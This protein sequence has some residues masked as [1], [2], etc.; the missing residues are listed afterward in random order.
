M[1]TDKYPDTPLEEV[2]LLE[3]V[4]LIYKQIPTTVFG[5]A[6]SSLLIIIAFWDYIPTHITLSWY[7]LTI[8]A[9][10][11]VALLS[12][13]FKNASPS[14]AQAR[15]WLKRGTPAT[16]IASFV[17]GL[18][19]YFL[20]VPD[21]II[22]QLILMIMYLTWSSLASHTVSTY[23]PA[24][25]IAVTTNLTPFTIRLLS[26][27][28]FIHII[29][30]C[31]LL[32]FTVVLVNYYHNTNRLVLDSIKLR[33]E[34][35]ALAKELQIQKDNAEQANL[36]KSRFLA[37]A[38]H[39]LR[40]PL[41]AL[42]LFVGELGARLSDDKCKSIVDKIEITTT[43]MSSLF[44]A[45]LDISKLDAGGIKPNIKTF[46]IND[47]LTELELESYPL[48]EAKGLNFRV[49]PCCV[50][51]RSDPALLISVLRNLVINAIR[52]TSSGGIVLG[53]RRKKNC[54]AV[55]VWDSGIG[56]P[57]DKQQLIF[58]E[59][60]QLDNPER[61][62]NK[63]IGL[64]LAISYRIASLLGHNIR[65][66]SRVGSGSR[67]IVELPM[68]KNK[69]VEITGSTSSALSSEKLDLND[70]NIIIIDDNQTILDSTKSLLNTWGCHVITA[71]SISSALD[72]MKISPHRPD[73]IIT[74]Y[75]LQGED[76]GMNAIEAI[77]SVINN[78]GKLVPALVVTGDIAPEIIELCKSNGYPVF[79]KPVRPEQL[80]KIISLAI[81]TS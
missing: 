66:I 25:Y 44:N 20:Y 10:T 75:R 40:Q 77:R 5:I 47:L 42:S 2:I 22:F 39:D 43:S 73:V 55:E 12:Q 30:I 76:T 1:N 72:Q 79:H 68:A 70:V 53:C 71:T 65:I 11:Y 4:K 54:I 57:E 61:D 80:R 7:A 59:F 26:D 45:L 21:S 48:A 35:V 24:F 34:H 37:A 31:A 69:A 6:A 9:W 23:P 29:M 60:Y 8:L 81:E 27:I 14:P 17:S 78:T 50:M 49:V 63:G 3:Q 64:G 41:H 13:Q 19:G 56:I 46:P 15:Y 62:Q 28:N 32:V 36:V 33:F 16:A 52:Y 67:F 51:V 58:Q 18:G 74:D 38:S